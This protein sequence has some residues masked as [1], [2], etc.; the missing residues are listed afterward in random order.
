V[1]L[2]IELVSAALP[3]TSAALRPPETKA[4]SDTV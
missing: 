3:E 4:A 2:F 1:S